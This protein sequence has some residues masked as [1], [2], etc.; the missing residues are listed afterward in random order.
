M[1]L[2]ERGDR[3]LFATARGRETRWLG[4]NGLQSLLVGI[5][6]APLKS[7]CL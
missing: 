7:G 4:H 5:Q 2:Q 3:V 6:I 1:N